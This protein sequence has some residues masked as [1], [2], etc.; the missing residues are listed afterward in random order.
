[1]NLWGHSSADTIKIPQQDST[2][3][4]IFSSIAMVMG[5]GEAGGTEKFSS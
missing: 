3:P 2:K 1:M 5:G 4:L